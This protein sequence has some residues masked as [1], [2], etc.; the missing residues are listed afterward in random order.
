[1]LDIIERRV[2]LSPLHPNINRTRARVPL[3]TNTRRES[4]VSSLARKIIVLLDFVHDL[5]SITTIRSMT[6]HL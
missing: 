5:S 2:P 4:L 3:T 1:M 6:Y